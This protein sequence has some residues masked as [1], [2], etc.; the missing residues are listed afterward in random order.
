MHPMNP[1][2]ISLHMQTTLQQK[3]LIHLDSDP[4]PHSVMDDMAEFERQLETQRMVTVYK[5]LGC[6]SFAP[7]EQLSDEQI[8]AAIDQL[9]AIFIDCNICIDFF[10]PY[11]PAEMYSAIIDDIFPEEIVEITAPGWVSHIQHTTPENE[12]HHTV[13]TFVELVLKGGGELLDVDNEHRP[14]ATVNNLSLD[15]A[16]FR[17]PMLELCSRIGTV[18]NADTTLQSVEI[19]GSTA[20]VKASIHWHTKAVGGCGEVSAKFILQ[21]FDES[22]QIVDTDFID[23]MLRYL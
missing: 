3:R 15:A 8:P 18:F 14:V 17:Q 4:L 20:H 2:P 11:T 19:S 13:A 10:G 16:S 12:I 9:L 21:D 1:H 23:R 5:R 6:P 22:W 7:L